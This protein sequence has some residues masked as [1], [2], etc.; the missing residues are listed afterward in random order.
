MVTNLPIK[1]HC[2][3]AAL[4]PTVEDTGL[5][6][7]RSGAGEAAFIGEKQDRVVESQ[8]PVSDAAST[9]TH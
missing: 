4:S 2:A 9:G 5:I 6:T 7:Y 3:N 1:N 8:L